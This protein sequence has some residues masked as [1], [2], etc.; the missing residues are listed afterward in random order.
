MQQHRILHI[1]D[2]KTD[3]D[4]IKRTLQKSGLSFEYRLAGNEEE[5]HK[6]LEEFVPDLI[7]CDHSL[8][9]FNSKMAYAICK[10]KNPDLSFILVTG[11]VSEEF[12]VD[13]MQTGVDDYL[14]KTNLQRLPIAIEK[15]Y[16]KRQNEKEVQLF[17][18]ELNQS[19]TRLRTIFDSSPVG[20]LLLDKEGIILELNDLTRYYSMMCF[21]CELEKNEILLKSIPEQRRHELKAKIEKS[22]KGEKIQCETVYL[23]QDGSEKTFNL[24]LSPTVIS[25]GLTSGICMTLE[26]VT[27]RK[28]TEEDIKN[29]ERQLN[30]IYNTVSDSFFMLS[31]EDGNRFKFI[32]VNSTFLKTTGLNEE[33][34]IDKYV[35]EVIP[36]PS[37]QLVLKKYNEAITLKVPVSWEEVTVFPSGIKTGF[38]TISPVLDE[39]N[40]CTMLVG[41]VHDIT[42]RKKINDELKN[43]AN[44]L[45]L[46]TQSTGMGIW[47]WDFKN[48]HLVWDNGMYKLYNIDDSQL[49]SVYQGW[50]SRLHPED[51][52]RVNE[53]IQTAITDKRK[54]Y[55][56]EFRIIW[57]DLSVHYIKGTGII[58][59]D[60]RGNAIRLVGINWDITQQKEKEQHLT[61]L[62]SVITNTSD[63]VVITEAEPF[64]EPGPRILF[65]NEAFT[66][67]TGYTAEEVIGKT[68]RILQGP[69]TDRQELKKLTKA[70]RQWQPFETSI[71]NYKKNGEEFWNNFSITP[72]TNETGFCTH[73]IAIERDITEQKLAEINLKQLNIDLKDHVKKLALSNEE[74]EQFAFVASHDLQEPLRMVTN[75]LTQLERK[76]GD[77]LD[78]K[79]KKYIGFAVDGAKRMRQII[80][81]LLELSRVGKTLERE[82]LIDLND[83]ISETKKLLAKKIAEKKATLVID[84]LPE[85]YADSTPI[86]QVFQNLITNA[87]EYSNKDIPVQIHLS[88]IET[89]DF[90]QFAV[91][92]NGIGISKEYHEKIFVIFQRLHSKEEHPGTGLGLAITKKII[93][94]HGGKIW[95]ESEEAR[96]D[97]AVGRGKGSTF[98]FTI[99]K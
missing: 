83:V 3:A 35:H 44:R 12:A 43:L 17:R 10:E 39:K 34:V 99:K 1:E 77:V 11:A 56:S 68:P 20:L 38:V 82:K 58:E 86:Q 14:L 36:S 65:V 85:I 93:E 74:L 75:Y 60:N 27:E 87:L 9:A 94:G 69:K 45:Q 59:Y 67:M 73:W 29:N 66:K 81:D 2:S 64:D 31:M 21:G 70:I 90:W 26:D 55:A 33:Q 96:P 16:L 52:D 63:A 22:L 92:D 5:V 62:E 25:Q 47:D 30:V 50:L 95:V 57:G 13:M 91:A 79:A 6:S 80:L 15:V 53:V 51:V 41:S 76:Y 78:D 32:S 37:L 4:L 48:D 61:L 49:G 88:A 98:Y 24:K 40:N 97:D 19:E 84:D 8:P 18:T 46:A 7:L 23:Q 89:E 42:E 71:I 54:E 72:V 28:K